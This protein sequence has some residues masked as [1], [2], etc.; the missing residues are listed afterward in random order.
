MPRVI[1][2]IYVHW[3]RGT[4][5]ERYM[6]SQQLHLRCISILVDVSNHAMGIMSLGRI[7]KLS[8]SVSGWSFQKWRRQW[9][10]QPCNTPRDNS[11]RIHCWR[12]PRRQDIGHGGM[13]RKL[14]VS[15]GKKRLLIRNKFGIFRSCWYVYGSNNWLMQ[16]QGNGSQTTPLVGNCGMLCCWNSEVMIHVLW[17]NAMYG[18]PCFFYVNGLKPVSLSTSINYEPVLLYV[19]K[20]WCPALANKSAAYIFAVQK[21]AWSRVQLRSAQCL[22]NS[23]LLLDICYDQ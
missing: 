14:P 16:L 11:G 8:L 19:R 18:V 9:H 4:C 13:H 12:H 6:C 10:K 2:C 22:I 7:D 17:C 20:C 5:W 15:M 21:H 23:H 1:L 3:L